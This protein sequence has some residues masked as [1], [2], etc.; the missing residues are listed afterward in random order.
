[1]HVLQIRA[2]PTGLT[3]FNN[4]NDQIGFNLGAGLNYQVKSNI[5]V[6]IKYQ[7]LQYQNFQINGANP[8]LTSIDIQQITPSFNLVG[9]ELRYYIN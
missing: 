6:G 8:A 4:Y 9:A 3:E 7:H 1:M 2:S 5:V